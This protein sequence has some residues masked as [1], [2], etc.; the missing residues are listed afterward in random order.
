MYIIRGMPTGLKELNLNIDGYQVSVKKSGRG[1]PL[2]LI[3]TWHPY[4]KRLAQSLPKGSYQIITFDAPGYYSKASGKLA[5]N[6]PNLNRILAGLSDYL[7]FEKVDLLGQCLGSVIALNF[8]A[9]YPERVRNLIATSPPL[10]CYQPE[11]NK[12]LRIIF[13]FMERNGI[14]KPL[15]SHLIVRHQLLQGITDIFG[16]YKGLADV[17]AQ[18][19]KL[20]SPASFNADVYFGLLSSTFKINLPE[21]LRRVQARTIFIAGEDDPLIWNGDLEKLAKTME[22]ASYKTIPSAKHAV[23]HKNTEDFHQAVLNFLRS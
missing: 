17:F 19:F 7:G 15:A 10:L 14:A 13:S 20:L 21:T 6:L 2:I 9:Q 4:A 11:V 5:T 12:S 16:G 22:N 3:H 8:A 23:V 18:D 1:F